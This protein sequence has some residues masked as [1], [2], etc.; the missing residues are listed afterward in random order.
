M[1]RR[2]D[3][4]RAAQKAQAPEGPRSTEGDEQLSLWK[5]PGFSAVMVRHG[6]FRRVVFASS[7]RPDRG[8]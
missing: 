1:T 7:Y 5:V 2:T 4:D 6:C 8:H 3:D